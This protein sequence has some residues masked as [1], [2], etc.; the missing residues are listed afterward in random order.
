AL[1]DHHVVVAP[2]GHALGAEL[3]L[4]AL[5]ERA[6][7]GAAAFLA[8][9]KRPSPRLLLEKE[10]GLVDEGIPDRAPVLLAQVVAAGAKHRLAQNGA[11]ER[12]EMDGGLLLPLVMRDRKRV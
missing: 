6:Q 5:L 8:S 9:G 2:E 3:H 7:A 10:D 1:S 11:K 4:E 12:V